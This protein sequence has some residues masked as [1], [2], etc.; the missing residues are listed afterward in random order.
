MIPDGD[1]L[2]VCRSIRK[3]SLNRSVPVLILTE[4]REESN[5]VLGLEI[6]ADDYLIKLF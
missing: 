2:T 3:G 5:K 4:K 6:G 1:G